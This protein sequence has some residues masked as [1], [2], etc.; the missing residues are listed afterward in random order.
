MTYHDEKYGLELKYPKPIY[1]DCCGENNMIIGLGMTSPTDEEHS[2]NVIGVSVRNY[3][4]L[5][6]WYVWRTKEFKT[7]AKFKN[8]TI[9]NLPA[10]TILTQIELYGKGTSCQLTGVLYQGKIFE[11]CD[12]LNNEVSEKIIKSIHFHSANTTTE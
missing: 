8:T 9:D 6:S 11:I 2:I 12:G 10:K 1:K 3:D 7:P 5:E 4:S